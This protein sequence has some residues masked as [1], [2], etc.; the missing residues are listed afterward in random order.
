MEKDSK[1]SVYVPAIF[2]LVGVIIGALI[3]GYFQLQTTK[4]ATEKDLAIESAKGSREL[5]AQ[6][7]ALSSEYMSSLFYFTAQTNKDV[8]TPEGMQKYLELQERTIKLALITSFPTSQKIAIMT[9]R[10][11]ELFSVP[12]GSNERNELSTKF[13]EDYASLL[14]AL[15]TEIARYRFRSTPDSMKDEALLILFQSMMNKEPNKTN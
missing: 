3:T 6:V 9:S 11:G 10:V 7:V 15:Y 12:L 5:Q 13:A 2:G 8:A 4:A 1:V 14:V